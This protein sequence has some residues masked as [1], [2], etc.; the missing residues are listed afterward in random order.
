MNKLNIPKSL[1][2]AGILLFAFS[3]PVSHVPAQFGIGIA[4]LGWLLEGI[5]HQRW[6]FVWHPFL[7]VLA[8]YVGWNLV[9]A[10]VSIRPAHSLAAVADNEWPALLMLM[11]FWTIDDAKFLSTVITTFFLTAGIAMLY[12]LWQVF[13]GV[14][15]YRNMTLDWIGGYYRA[16]GFYSFYLT[17]AAFALTV[18][19]FAAAFALEVKKLRVMHLLLALLSFGAIIGSFARSVWLA[20]AAGIP[21]FGFLKNRTL[22]IGITAFAIVL[23][24]SAVLIEPTI[25][26]RAE[27]ILDVSQ[28]QTR[29]NLWKTS[30]NIF[31]AHPFLGV[32]EDNFDAVFD[33]YKVEGYYDTTVHPHNDYLSVL[34]ASGL[35]GLLAFLG[36]WAIALR[37]GLKGWKQASDPQLRAILLG[38]IFSLFGLLIAAFFQ[39]YYGSFI[40]CL[41]W[42]F[43]VGLVLTAK[44]LE[45]RNSLPQISL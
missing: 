21:L 36:M 37:E 39:N 16:V 43:V 30:L 24:A 17:F 27:S 6:Q 38:G 5:L 9:S 23:V 22:G 25:R 26:Y 12:A 41:G 20:L 19:F 28:N 40:N 1:S 15:F 14:E 7:G 35:P 45:Q 4:F 32:G 3:L 13:G 33:R 8:F 34:V 18:F 44:K 10:A 42:W 2:R 31:V 11:M 29:L